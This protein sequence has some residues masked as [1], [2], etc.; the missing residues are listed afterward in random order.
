MSEKMP[1]P[2]FIPLQRVDT[3]SFKPDDSAEEVGRQRR[4]QLLRATLL[5][6][7]PATGLAALVS[8]FLLGTTPSTQNPEILLLASLAGL[9]A[10]AYALNRSG[11]YLPAALLTVSASSVAVVIGEILLLRGIGP[12]PESA[13][14]ALLFYLAV[15]V[16]LA[17]MLLPLGWLT[18]V[19]AL[20]LVAIGLW[21]LLFPQFVV[22]DIILGPFVFVSFASLLVLLVTYQRHRAEQ[23]RRAES[24]EN[25]E[26]LEALRQVGLEIAAELNLADLLHSI[27]SRAL[28]LV[29]ATSGGIYIYRP[30]QDVIEWT[31]AVGPLLSPLGVTLQRGEGLSGKVWERGEPLMVDDYKRWEGRANAYDGLPLGATLGVPI[32]WGQEFLGVLDVLKDTPQRF[33]ARDAEL[34]S[35]FAT[36]AALAIKNARLFQGEREQRQLAESL[37]QATAA[38]SSILD[39]DQV[40]DGILEQMNRVIPSETSNIMLVKD[41]C[42]QIVRSRGYEKFGGGDLLDAV[43]F[44]I[45]DTPT[46]RYMQQN[47]EPIIVSDTTQ[48]EGW[49]RVS[50]WVRS[51][52][53]API[54]VRGQIIG[55]LNVNSSTPGFFNQTHAKHLRAF[56]GPA[57]LAIQ[58]A[59]LFK[60]TSRRVE[61][62]S[63]LHQI[64][65][66]L[67]SALEL[68][69]VL[70]TLYDETR[71]IVDVGAFYVAL[72]DQE[73]GRIDFPLLTGITGPGYIA[74]LDIHERPG[75]TGYIIQSGQPLYVPDTRLA[76]E[77]DSALGMIPLIDLPARSYIGV[78]LVRRDEVIGVLSV[79]SYE[80]RAY[81]KADV[82]LLTTIASQATIAIENAR[83]FRIL[84]Q[85]KREW[86]TS[87]DA[88][89]DG[90]ALVDQAGQVLR[91]NLAFAHLV[92]KPFQQ[93]IGRRYTDLLV[94][95]T[96]TL[97]H[98]R[99][100]SSA[101]DEQPA[102]CLHKYDHHTFEVQATPVPSA[103]DAAPEHPASLI[104][105]IR[106]VS[107]RKRA[108]EEIRQRN[109]ELALLN[110]VIA[111]CASRHEID[112]ILR[113][114][115]RQLG[116]VLGT[117]RTEAHLLD[118]DGGQSFVVVAE[119]L[120][121]GEE[122][123]LGT[124]LSAPQTRIVR[125]L[126]WQ[127]GT[128]SVDDLQ[129]DPRRNRVCEALF[130]PGSAS[131][132]IVPLT[133]EGVIVGSLNLA[134]REA[135]AFG[136]V[137]VDLVNRAA[138]QVSGALARTRL[139]ETQRRLST[140]VEQ[141][142]EGILITDTEGLIVYVNPA[143]ERITGGKREAL[144]GTTP[145]KLGNVEYKVYR[146]MW[147]VLQHGQVWKGR[148]AGKR[149]D[150]SPFIVDSTVTP[151][152]NQAGEIV[153]HVATL[154]DVTREVE[155]EE[156]FQ[157]SQ[158]ME[159]LGRLAGGIAHDF[160]NLLTV[161]QISVRLLERSLRRE[162]PLWEHVQ[163]I[164]ETSER[165]TAL[166]K[167]LLSFSRHQVVKAEV[168]NLN[169]IVA[170]LSRMLQRI[171]GEDI[172]LVTNL[173]D[174]LWPIRAD[175]VQMDQVLMNLVV[176][177]RDAMPDGGAVTIETANAVLDE[178]YAA[179]HV[180][181]SAGKY[182]RLSI[183]DTGMGMDSE[184]QAHLFEPFF[185]TKEQ[186]RGTGLG[187]ATVFGIVKQSKGHIE[188]QSE[189]GKGT[190]FDIYLPRAQKSAAP[191]STPP[192]ATE[193]PQ[194]AEGVET[195]LIA[196]DEQAVRELTAQI[197]KDQGYNVLVAGNGADALRV[198]QQYNGDIHLL[199]TD[200]IMPQMNGQEL[201]E[202]L[203][204]TRPEIRV[205]FMSGYTGD[206]IAQR[207]ALAPGT[208]PFIVKPLTLEKLT[209]KVRAVL[210]GQA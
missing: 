81:T 190:K 173:A 49:K 130:R 93:I 192:A 158:K 12:V 72:Y 73:T 103:H 71:R 9:L 161:I 186:D 19:V 195:I 152:R 17:S 15:P 124:S 194:L 179:R 69:D 66:A 97:D 38:V 85:G 131:L 176:N 56:A 132:L 94:S 181:A 150:G 166:N 168:L 191:V 99:L 102:V 180:D 174:D 140:A 202:Q 108:E 23:Q 74:P 88:M 126:L 205:L 185:T 155:L 11:R 141:A 2:S 62:L 43:D 115:C 172:E 149:P 201:A 46:L 20:N 98:C 121:P 30:E 79:Q 154:H 82:E 48:Y 128:L 184:V 21:P 27:T 41:E 210:D 31:A 123:A 199:L 167:Q 118:P 143:L 5:I 114:V 8:Q 204:V 188:V 169:R 3:P 101:Q 44:R 107:E 14:P 206:A 60:E 119:H 1:G 16:F 106:D 156:Q 89:Q 7:L 64:G 117:S 197:L 147:R 125:R 177:A 70:N 51:Y 32:V 63:T 129:A 13:G 146:E 26:R 138:D 36:Q 22:R 4:T 52:A 39:L 178:A 104:Y 87:F 53:G 193:R 10:L 96:C 135:S 196:E 77:Q 59:R 105:T 55:Y 208:A 24:A 159:A 68:E 160:N 112:A 110:R 86:E 162:D 47:G 37:Q 207:S 175:P 142:A 29:D 148:M 133:V 35:L 183:R 58:N 100:E 113:T 151:V 187:L 90:V 6:L 57:S 50:E 144:I 67:T 95:M 163:R 76:M 75:I 139:E 153:N 92:R 145:D 33:T 189:M 136:S 78:P 91:A 25:E 203:R 80:P 122:S 209:G 34:L 40:F 170:D 18:L 61:Q 157:Q 134:A 164:V 111:T 54:S 165:A 42:V 116:R 83:L 198:S 109:R 28:S 65:I 127:E 137:E 171:I 182:V 84:E 45:A 200:V 120:S